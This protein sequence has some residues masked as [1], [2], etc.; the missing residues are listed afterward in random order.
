MRRAGLAIA[1]SVAVSGAAMIGRADEATAPESLEP[2]L[3]LPGGALPAMPETVE[4]GDGCSTC[5]AR[6]AAKT[7]AR[8]AKQAASDRNDTVEGDD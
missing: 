4:A 7:R 6:Q 3:A 1:L 8:K 5:D 2:P